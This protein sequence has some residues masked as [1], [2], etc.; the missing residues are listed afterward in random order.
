MANRET[1]KKSAGGKGSI[2]VDLGA[3]AKIGVDIKTE[4][5]RESS[6]RLVDALTD[7]IRPFS[8]SRGLKADRLR[9][10]REEVLYE[11]ARRAKERIELEQSDVRPLSNKFLV[12]LLEKASLE[13]PSDE[14]LIQMWSNLLATAL[15]SKVELLGQYVNI[16]ANLTGTQARIFDDVVSRSLSTDGILLK[17]GHFVD[18]YYYLNQTGLPGTLG[19]LLKMRSLEKFARKLM[20]EV[21]GIGVAIDTMNVYPKGDST[22]GISLSGQKDGPYRDSLFFD[23]E[24]LCR[25]GLLER[26]EIKQLLLGNFDLDIFYYVVTPVG[27]DLFACCNPTKIVRGW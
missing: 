13:D 26:V 12:P 22:G 8:E 6:G 17:T 7:L 15:T 2:N 4:V 5:P 16:I 14:K 9:L 10:E 11:I 18:Q 3:S 1:R 25:V 21:D 27:I 20:E 24:N 23:F 19:S